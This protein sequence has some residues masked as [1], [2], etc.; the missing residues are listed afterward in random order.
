MRFPT[1]PAFLALSLATAAQS[2]LVIDLKPGGG[3]PGSGFW[4]DQSIALGDELLFSGDSG[5][6]RSLWITDGT[7]AGTRLVHDIH[8]GLGSYP[9]SFT[10]LGDEVVFL[11]NDPTGFG[12][13]WKTDGTSAGTIS[14]P[15]PAGGTLTCL[16]PFRGEVYFSNHTLA[17]AELWKTDGT[18][19]GTM[20]LTP[21]PEPYTTTGFA[22]LGDELIF[23]TKY[24]G[25]FGYFE[26]WKTDGTPAGT[27]LLATL[28]YGLADPAEFTVLGDAL[29]F[30]AHDW[31]TG[32]ELWRSD[33]TPAGTGL[34]ADLSPGP[35]ST[36]PQQLEVLDGEL[37]LFA[38]FGGLFGPPRGLWVSDGTVAGTHLL[39]QN[40]DKPVQGVASVGA[41][42][43][44]IAGFELWATDGTLA[45][46]VFVDGPLVAWLGSPEPL[47]AGSGDELIF[48][49]QTY[50][51]TTPDSDELWFT[52]GVQVAKLVDVHPGSKGSFCKTFRR[53]GDL[54]YFSADDGTTGQELHA[55]PLVA[56][57][58]W[59]GEP[60]GA[61][62]GAGALAPVLS[63]QGEATLGS[64]VQVHLEGAAPSAAAVLFWSQ[65][66]VA[67][68][69]GGGCTVYLAGPQPLLPH[70]TGAT[71]AAALPIAIPDVPALLGLALVL[72][73]VVALPGGPLLGAAE[74]S[75]GLELVLGP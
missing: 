7:A 61:G 9:S 17:G 55:I 20:P 38:D 12:R 30:T 6:G 53:A 57:G 39:F 48:R 44:F 10:P 19:A 66:R 34:F 62:C 36:A 2:T 11:A 24:F 5:S 25:A 32:R 63:L 26:I 18:P 73:D 59:L 14:L 28:S 60:F 4:D 72:Q 54:L 65:D 69:L 47:H 70:A 67:Q 74:L 64:A 23:A 71:G 46:T 50:T 3:F 33:G 15:T 8:P 13:L 51:T 1:A 22:V 68:D 52:D 75:G 58:G 45:G 27:L 16:T 43:Y 37:L 49:G 42:G 31:D 56:T 29:F 41:K 21:I 40:A 35:A